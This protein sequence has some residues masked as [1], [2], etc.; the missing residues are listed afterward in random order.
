M[1][2]TFN[3]IQ[4]SSERLKKMKAKLVKKE[5]TVLDPEKGRDNNFVFSLVQALKHPRDVSGMFSINEARSMFNC[6]I[7]ERGGDVLDDDETKRLAENFIVDCVE[8]NEEDRRLCGL[9]ENSIS[10]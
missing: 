6:A 5:A 2:N 9:I 7:H 8:C 3:T 10:I 1:S 4:E